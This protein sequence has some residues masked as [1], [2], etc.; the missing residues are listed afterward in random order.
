MNMYFFLSGSGRCGRHRHGFS[1]YLV[2]IGSVILITALVI[3]PQQT[4]VR[5]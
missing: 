1:F 4:F 2:I 5:K 3:D